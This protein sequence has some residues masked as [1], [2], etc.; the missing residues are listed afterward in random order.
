MSGTWTFTWSFLLLTQIL[1][2]V[3]I[4]NNSEA[5]LKGVVSKYIC[6][7]TL[8]SMA[9]ILDLPGFMKKSV[10]MP[11]PVSLLSC[12]PPAGV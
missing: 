1:F 9:G 5:K 12:F 2:C 4:R 11:F 3:G 10:A 8:L 6:F 7:E